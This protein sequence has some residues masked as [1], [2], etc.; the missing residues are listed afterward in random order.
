MEAVEASA[1]LAAILAGAFLVMRRRQQQEEDETLEFTYDEP[2]ETPEDSDPFDSD[3]EIASLDEP[4]DEPVDSEDDLF[5]EAELGDELDIEESVPTESQTGDAVGEADI[6]IAYGKFD[7]AE[8]MLVNALAANPN[9]ASAR[10]KLMEVYVETQELEKFD[11]QYGQVQASGDADALARAN[12]LRE[13]FDNAPAYIAMDEAAEACAVE[14]PL[15]STLHN[16]QI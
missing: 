14:L 5:E 9:D 2:V 10:L 15:F 7:Q 12:D 4:A 13:Q 16:F 6:Y 1:G 11:N 3:A 8:E